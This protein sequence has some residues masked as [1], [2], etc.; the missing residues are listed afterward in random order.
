MTVDE[1]KKI[2]LSTKLSPTVR[3]ALNV[4]LPDL[5]SYGDLPGEE[6]RDVVGFGGG[7]QVSNFGRVKSLLKGKIRILKTH[8][9]LGYLGISLEIGGKKKNCKVHRLVA[10]AFIP[11]PEN[12]PEVNHIDGDKLNSFAQVLIGSAFLVWYFQTGSKLLPLLV[13]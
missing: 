8:L 13:S 11:N 12:K 1:A 7:Y 4:L 9:T 10:E 5:A 3:E 6:W 2:L